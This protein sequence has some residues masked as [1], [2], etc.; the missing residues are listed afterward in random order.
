MG[1]TSQ[2]KEKLL[3][4]PTFQGAANDDTG[5]MFVS[6]MDL[7]NSRTMQIDTVLM[8]CA[9]LCSFSNRLEL[10]CQ[11]LRHAYGRREIPYSKYAEIRGQ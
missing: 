10:G 8:V 9:R 4:T 2:T 11:Y 7:S 1:V 5:L 6:G 3:T